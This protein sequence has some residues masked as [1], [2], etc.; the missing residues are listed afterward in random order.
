VQQAVAEGDAVHLTV[1]DRK[2]RRTFEIDASW[3]VNCTG[4][5][6]A[7][8]PEA[9][10]VIGSLLL[11]GHVRPD[12]LNLG[13]ETSATGAPIRA[14]GSETP[15]LLVVGTLC[16]PAYWECI[17]VPELRQHAARGAQTLLDERPVESPALAIPAD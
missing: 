9:N 6:P 14:D 17:A 13:L 2:G 3:V 11:Q 10:P 4:P 5:T 16:K 7:N 12:A 8:H 1:R 15:D